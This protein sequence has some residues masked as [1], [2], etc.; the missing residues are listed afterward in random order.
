M[1]KKFT[2]ITSAGSAIPVYDKDAHEALSAKLDTTALAPAIE[3]AVSGKAD[4]SAI[5][6]LDGYATQEWVGEQGYLTEVPES[7]VS[8]FATHEEVESAT[9]G[10]ADTSDVVEYRSKPESG[11][12][13]ASANTLLN[14]NAIGGE[15]INVQSAQLYIN[16]II[17]ATSG[18]LTAAGLTSDTD[19]AWGGFT[20]N[21]LTANPAGLTASGLSA[22]AD[23]AW[24]GFSANGISAGPRTDFA[25]SGRGESLKASNGA[26]FTFSSVN[27]GIGIASL[28]Y[29]NPN[30]YVKIY[31]PKFE[32]K[33]ISGAGFSIEGSGAKGYDE[34][35]NVVW[36]TTKPAKL[37]GWA[38]Y[39]G[40]AID[41]RASGI[42]GG[43]IAT[44]YPDQIPTAM[45]I[46]SAP[47][48]YMNGYG[49][50]AINTGNGTTL[51]AD[52]TYST[53]GLLHTGMSATAAMNPADV[54]YRKYNNETSATDN[55][56]LTGSVQKREIECDSATSAITAIAGS[57]VGGGS[58]YSAG[59]NIDITDD[60]ISGKDWTEEITSATSGLQPSGDYYSASNPS[61]FLVPDD[62]TGK[63]D[64]TGMTAY[65]PA[66]DYQPSGDYY[67]ASN[68]SG[69]LTELPASATDV[70]DTVTA[71]SGTWGGS[72]L[73]ISAGPGIKFDMV[74]G[75]LVA[76]TDETVLWTG[77][78]NSTSFT[79]YEPISNF[80]VIEL[81]NEKNT[82]SCRILVDGTVS[83]GFNY[84]RLWLQPD[85]TIMQ[86]YYAVTS[87][88]GQTFGVRYV[89]GADISTAGAT[90]Y[91]GG[92]DWYLE[93]TKIVGI[94]RVAGGI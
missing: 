72:A 87:N 52:T 29:S 18:Y 47:Y 2:G 45:A 34:N 74:N 32:A 70:I 26:G 12:I 37:I 36:D 43:I 20:A 23:S 24:G 27:T 39:Q 10:K 84:N 65:Q 75:T 30:A 31:S 3:A 66:G 57:A 85:N 76:S 25:I 6:S 4:S 55:W 73:P 91:G 44:V 51:S 33:N 86:R 79:L 61:G 16:G 69:F 9:S 7:A 54:Y 14:V 5:P 41:P 60:V 82:N 38:N 17:L 21:G 56:S 22:G 88:D 92:S 77:N 62:V 71:N 83:A 63:M 67:S 59:D 68:P 15:S 13:Y 19:S 90:T 35:G 50:F 48:T 94:G 1:S 78:N 81:Y 93:N 49:F 80:K 28:T 89:R 42:N 53:I 8:G 40:T 46:S 58:T 64:V 11:A